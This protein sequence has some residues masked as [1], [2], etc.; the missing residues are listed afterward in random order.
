MRVGDGYAVRQSFGP[1]LRW[2][3]RGQ[4]QQRAGESV[5][6]PSTINVG[7]GMLSMR[8]WMEF[9]RTVSA[10]DVHRCVVGGQGFNDSSMTS[11]FLPP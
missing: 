7:D 1:V 9:P 4:L 3:V 10:G 5:P 11:T 6:G 2:R 8:G